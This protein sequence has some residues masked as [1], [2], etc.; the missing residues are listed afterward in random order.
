MEQKDM[1]PGHKGVPL[2]HRLSQAIPSHL[3]LKIYFNTVHRL[4]CTYDSQRGLF[5]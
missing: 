4:T 3:F 5:C 2:V 1:L